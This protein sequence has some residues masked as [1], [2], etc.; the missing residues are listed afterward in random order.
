M[1]EMDSNTDLLNYIETDLSFVR[2]GSLPELKVLLECALESEEF[3]IA[4]QL[5]K[6]IYSYD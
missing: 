1:R 3:E 5:K 4:E 6:Q 2:K